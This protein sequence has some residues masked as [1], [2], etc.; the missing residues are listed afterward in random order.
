MATNVKQA[1][2]LER[3]GHPTPWRVPFGSVNEELRNLGSGRP[4]EF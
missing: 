4:R 2:L 3:S 1:R